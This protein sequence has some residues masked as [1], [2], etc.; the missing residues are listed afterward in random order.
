MSLTDITESRFIVKCPNCSNEF[1]INSD[2]DITFDD[3]SQI[4]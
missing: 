3:F 4:I 1:N 2:E